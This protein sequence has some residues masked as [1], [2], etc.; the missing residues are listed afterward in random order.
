[1]KRY[2]ILRVNI[3]KEGLILLKIR[4]WSINIYRNKL[5]KII[6]NKKMIKIPNKKI[7]K[8]H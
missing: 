5:I 2:G 8:N 1:M 4:I 3:C 7:D 6:H